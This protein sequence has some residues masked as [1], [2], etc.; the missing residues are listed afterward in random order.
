MIEVLQMTAAPRGDD[1]P[2]VLM[3]SGGS[4]STALLVR[5]ATGTLDLA[6]GRGERRL[7]TSC[8]H[9][10][11]IDHCLR[12]DDSTGDALFVERLCGHLGVDCRVRRVDVARAI[13]LTGDNMEDYARRVRYAAA[14]ELVA[15]LAARS[16]VGPARCRVLV[17]HTADDRLETFLMRVVVGAGASG[18]TGMRAVRGIVVRPLLGESRADLR[19]YLVSGGYGWREDATNAQTVALRSYVRNRVVPV[20]EERNPS[21]RSTV[22]TTL[23]V[24]AQEDE[25]MAGVAREAYGRALLEAVPAQ[26]DLDAPKSLVLDPAV[27]SGLDPAV[28]RR[29][30]RLALADAYGSQGFED[31]RLEASHIEAVLGIARRAGGSCTLPLGLDVR[32]GRGGL[33]LTPRGCDVSACQPVL[34]PVPGKAVWGRRVLEAR[35]VPVPQGADPVAFARE[36][37]SAVRS[38][39]L[40][41]RAAQPGGNPVEGRDYVLVDAAALRPCDPS[42]PVVPAPSAPAAPADPAADLAPAAPDA[43]G[44]AAAGLADI[45]ALEVGAPKPGER[46]R[47]FGM[48]ESKL[49]SDVIS[50]A[51]VPLRRRPEVPVLRA[52]GQVVWVG[53]IRLDVR[54]AYGPNTSVLVELTAMCTE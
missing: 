35:L 43:A 9:V 2:V 6:D 51:G 33:A 52:G 29:T 5:A 44:P 54:A 7:P 42:A 19:S 28:A 41:G 16:G 13:G 48:G 37:S 14:S 45:P 8:L 1:D 32:M 24:L 3:V 40:D 30:L 17:A 47:P 25:Y 27:L 34:L 36:R 22:A 18:L 46:M 15:E 10:L 50:E 11:H 38:R 39:L 20:L 49:V 53:G 12:G 21:I 4:D 23:E 26:K 31:A